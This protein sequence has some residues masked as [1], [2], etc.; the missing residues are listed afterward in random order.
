MCKKCGKIKEKHKNYNYC[1]Y[2]G[3]KLKE[4]CFI[5]DFNAPLGN[6]FIRVENGSIVDRG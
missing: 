6:L 4:I 2:C 1:P 3:K 5:P